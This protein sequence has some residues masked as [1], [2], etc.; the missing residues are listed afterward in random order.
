MRLCGG[1]LCGVAAWVSDKAGGK[2]QPR[3]I[4]AEREAQGT[5][6][7]TKNGIRG[8][9]CEG[10]VVLAICWCEAVFKSVRSCFRDVK[11]DIISTTARV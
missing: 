11:I 2:H 5:D 1:W 7:F 6:E 8:F 9:I 3:A 10:G 4:S